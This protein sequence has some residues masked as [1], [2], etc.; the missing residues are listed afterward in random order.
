MGNWHYDPITTRFTVQLEPGVWLAPWDGD[1]GRTLV[2]DNA[3]K[4]LSEGE[5]ARAL[6]AARRCRAFAAATIESLP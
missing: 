5:A 2:R 1:P 4:F 6:E 3:K